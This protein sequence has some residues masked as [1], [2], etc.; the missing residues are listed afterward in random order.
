MD[1]G[2]Y[3]LRLGRRAMPRLTVDDPCAFSRKSDPP[4]ARQEKRELDGYVCRLESVRVDHF[5]IPPLRPLS[6]TLAVLPW[7]GR[8]YVS[9]IAMFVLLESC[10]CQ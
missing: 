6:S 8:N 4:T 5:L 3:H 7:L 10:H 9:A 2:W 1:H